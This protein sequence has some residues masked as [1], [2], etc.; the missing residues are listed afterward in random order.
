M[1]YTLNVEIGKWAIRLMIVAS[2]LVF[3]AVSLVNHERFL[4]FGWDLGFYDQIAWNL[5][6]L[7]FP[8]STFISAPAFGVRFSP[9][10]LL[11]APFYRLFPDARILLV[12]QAL[13]ATLA[14]YPLYLLGKR[15][16]RSSYVGI[17]AALSYLT[18]IGLERAVF[19][20]F[21]PDTIL[22]FFITWSLYFAHSKRL[23]LSLFFSLLMLLCKEW[24]GLLVAAMGVMFLFQKQRRLGVITAAFG[25]VGFFSVIYLVLPGLGNSGTSVY[26]FG[27]FGE[28]PHQALASI[29]T[30][31]LAAILTIVTPQ[32][33]LLTLFD[34]FWP[35]AFLPI[36]APA[37]LIPIFLQFGVRFFDVSHQ[38]S[39]TL[40]Y[41]Y[42]APLTPFLAYGS[43]M[44]IRSFKARWATHLLVTTSLLGLILFHAP[45]FTLLKSG[46]YYQPA[47]IA[48]TRAVL[49][50]VP[51]DVPV[52][53]QNNLI[54]HLS[55]REKVYPLPLIGDAQYLVVDLHPN[56]SEY[57]YSTATRV[58]IE[59]LVARLT[60]SGDFFVSFKQGDA[61]L[62]QRVP[63]H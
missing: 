48:D 19:F 32:T 51:I 61:I 7:R 47:W 35:F 44:G 12:G 25:L 54:P 3:T 58:G 43:I 15:V 40:L 60:F 46:F 52:A 10:L 9:I 21:H 39:W 31:P 13:L 17:A 14:A 55:S 29:I 8:F 34:S 22:P 53:A 2:F 26:S 20:D 33:K 27:E 57:N 42:S 45:V 24:V 36:A 62:F 6:R 4:T 5:S 28:S 63:S 37:T 30:H 23:Y 16:T 1:R 56:Q 49:A 41:H 11:F 50:R 59:E 38:Q 18:F